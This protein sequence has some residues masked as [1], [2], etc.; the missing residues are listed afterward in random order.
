MK[1]GLHLERCCGVFSVSLPPTQWLI[2]LVISL[3]TA[4]C[5]IVLARQRGLDAPVA[6]E[7]SVLIR[8]C[9]CVC[10]CL[11]ALEVCVRAKRVSCVQIEAA[12]Y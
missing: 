6:A 10:M 3:M 5:F 7:A 4:D 2:A 8:L 11:C 12:P 1:W 9:L